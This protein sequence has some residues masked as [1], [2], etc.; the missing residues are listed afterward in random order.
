MTARSE[1]LINFAIWCAFIALIMWYV[2]GCRA[3]TK[4][5]GDPTDTKVIAPLHDALRRNNEGQGALFK[6][7]ESIDPK[8]TAAKQLVDPVAKAF[9]DVA[10]Y[11][12]RAIEGAGASS[13]AI[14]DANK[15]TA[16]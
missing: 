10:A 12:S 9:Q 1:K 16:D 3:T 6:L 2:A 13:K 15:Q 14:S 7:G 5:V 8:N 11:V 4:P